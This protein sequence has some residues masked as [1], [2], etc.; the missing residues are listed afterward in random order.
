MAGVG[1]FQESGV[2][3]F[4]LGVPAAKF[5]SIIL[6]TGFPFSLKQGT[7]NFFIEF[8]NGNHKLVQVF[9]RISYLLLG[10]WDIWEN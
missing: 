10:I 3:C 5:V 1:P 2:I 6:N 9:S 4:L 8:G 7:L